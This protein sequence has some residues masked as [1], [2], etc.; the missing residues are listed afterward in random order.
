M[1]FILQTSNF[2]LQTILVLIFICTL[3]ILNNELLRSVNFYL[4]TLISYFLFAPLL[5]FLFKWTIL[6]KPDRIIGELSYPIYL[7]HFYI[8]RL[9][10]GT[11]YLLGKDIFLCKDININAEAACLLSILTAFL[12]YLFFIR[13]LEEFRQRRLFRI[14]QL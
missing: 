13:K 8:I 7:V 4:S 12:I 10:D 6:S 11:R 1:S 5:S 9:M 14:D 2:K 3:I